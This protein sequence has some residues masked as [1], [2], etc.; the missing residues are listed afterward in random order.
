MFTD[1]DRLAP[2]E[3][4]ASKK[5]YD[6]IESSF[7]EVP[8]LN[9]PHLTLLRYDLLKRLFGEG[10][11]SFNVI[12]VNE[13]W[14]TLNYPVFVRSEHVHTYRHGLGLAY[15]QQQLKRNIQ[16]HLNSGFPREKLIITELCNVSDQ[17]GVFN[18]YAAYLVNGQVVP[19][20]LY[21]SKDWYVAS[22]AAK[23][24]EQINKDRFKLHAEY[25]EKNPHKEWI[26]KMF[27]HAGT[28]Y[29][30]IDYGLL[31]DKPQVWEINLNPNF[32][33]NVM[34]TNE[35]SSLDEK[36][37]NLFQIFNQRFIRALDSIDYQSDQHFDLNV[38]FNS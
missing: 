19:R 11:N 5:L 29:G 26:L 21:Y 35:G 1:L 23:K 28:N 10:I 3:L 30:R 27:E 14:N 33:T 20:H 38:A 6:T 9:N 12:K 31:G 17:D 24:Y 8:I 7:P 37:A 18:N 15:N 16:N 4:D 32:S 22:E 2:S 34:A 25:I 36:R 13:D